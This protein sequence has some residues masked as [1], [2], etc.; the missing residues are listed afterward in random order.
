VNGSKVTD[1]GSHDNDNMANVCPDS[2]YN[3][4]IEVLFSSRKAITYSK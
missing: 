2:S 4:T 3:H 1:T